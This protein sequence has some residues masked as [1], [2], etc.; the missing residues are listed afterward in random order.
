MFSGLGV[1]RVM[2]PVLATFL[3]IGFVFIS[4]LIFKRHG[5]LTAGIMC[6]VT[7]VLVNKH[8]CKPVKSLPMI[9][10]G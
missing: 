4:H 2:A 7:C 8:H 9:L 3:F 10:N 6:C 5:K 1:L